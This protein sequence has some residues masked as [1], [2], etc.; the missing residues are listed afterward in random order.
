[1]GTREKYAESEMQMREY[2]ARY[3]ASGSTAEE[4]AKQIIYP[5]TSSTIGG[6]GALRSSR[7]PTQSDVASVG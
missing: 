7:H 4:F 6:T 1:M 2:F 3:E 5:F